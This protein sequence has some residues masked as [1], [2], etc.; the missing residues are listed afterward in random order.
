MK[1]AKVE[2]I[3]VTFPVK[4]ELRT[5]G[6]AVNPPLYSGGKL[7]AAELD[8][9]ARFEALA[10]AALEAG[11]L[12]SGAPERHNGQRAGHATVNAVDAEREPRA[13]AAS[14]V[15]E[16]RARAGDT[17][18]ESKG[19]QRPETNAGNDAEVARS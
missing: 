14:T 4:R 3:P 6:S 9:P 13:S 16:P 15:R 17:E 11:A 7:L 2:V 18:R 19:A 5:P 1:I 10:T 8:D 12:A